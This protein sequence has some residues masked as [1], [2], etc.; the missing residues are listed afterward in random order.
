MQLFQ[1]Y[2]KVRKQT[3]TICQPLCPEDFVV[4]PVEDVSPPKWHLAHT[5]WFFETF[6]LVPHHPTYKLFHPSYSFLFNS[7]YESVGERVIRA[8]RGNLSRPTTDEIMEY[9][10]HVDQAMEEVL[11][12][13][14]PEEVQQLL[15]VGLHHEQQHQELLVT[16]IKY[17]LGNNPLFPA[18][19]KHEESSVEPVKQQW[20][21]ME[22]GLYEIGYKGNDFCWD[23]E[24]GAHQVYLEDFALSNRLVT[25]GE[26]LEFIENGGYKQFDL[27]LSEAW[28]WVNEEQIKAP[29]YWHKI[30]DKWHFFNMS[31]LQELDLN[32]PVTH[33]SF[34]EAD[35]YAT[36][37]GMR[38]PS[39]A[40]WEVVAL[41]YG[42][43]DDAQNNYLDQGSYK[44]VASANNQLFGNCWE[45]TNSSYLPY[46]NYDKP[47]GALGEYNGKFMINQMVLR[48][49]S[50]ATPADH[51]RPTYRNFFPTNARWQF[52]GI[53]LAKSI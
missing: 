1:R 16:D 44:P 31:G 25:N 14:V 28:T 36:W 30:K 34:F 18:Y 10:K 48:G 38:L 13:N 40:E 22:K 23:N 12:A 53:R 24:K 4:Q 8:T 6:I 3:E 47:A 20:L 49:G 45:W 33:V 19:L 35:A 7:Y 17:I 29:L 9:R 51:I 50:C 42:K 2:Q 41:K 32:A 43:I 37:K 11:T 39:E 21:S 5:T 27:W 26:F 15:T 52:S 46:P